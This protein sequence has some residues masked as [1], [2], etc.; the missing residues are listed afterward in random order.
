MRYQPTGRKLR[1]IGFYDWYF[2]IY[3]LGDK[4]TEISLN[5]QARQNVKR[6]LL[7][8]IGIS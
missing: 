3:L 6:G 4:W 1:Q 5:A 8:Q 7:R 2:F